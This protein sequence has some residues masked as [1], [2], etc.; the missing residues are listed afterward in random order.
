M[1]SITH[2]S[3]DTLPGFVDQG[4]HGIAV[5]AAVMPSL[6]KSYLRSQTLG[7]G[8]LFNLSGVWTD[9]LSG[10]LP[11]YQNLV[12]PAQA[13]GHPSFQ[14]PS[15]PDYRLVGLF[16]GEYSVDIDIEVSY[17]QSAT[18]SSSAV[19]LSFKGIGTVTIK[20]TTSGM[21]SG[22][23]MGPDQQAGLGQQ[24]T[25]WV[26]VVN[27]T[28]KPMSVPIIWSNN[29]PDQTGDYGRQETLNVQAG[30][31]VR[32]EYT[33]TTPSEWYLGAGT[34]IVVIFNATIFGTIYKGQC[35]ILMPTSGPG[36]FP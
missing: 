15:N 19:S 25:A 26:D 2:K 14:D 27:A 11:E 16:P 5:S 8:G 6:V 30:E 32:T 22:I 29:D 28:N 13:I 4:V 23:R 36:V 21:K 35:F 18:G 12:I 31:I 3:A 1:M 10:Y 24:V 20:Q 33:F 17:W 9:G 34:V 7:S